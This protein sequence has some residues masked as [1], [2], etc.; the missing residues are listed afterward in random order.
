MTS[1]RKIRLNIHTRT[2]ISKFQRFEDGTTFGPYRSGIRYSD[3]RSHQKRPHVVS[4]NGTRD[5]NVLPVDDIHADRK[6]YKKVIA[7]DRKNDK[8]IHRANKHKEYLRCRKPV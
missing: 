7:A 4:G 2:F 6:D 5:L 8:A 1:A 3:V